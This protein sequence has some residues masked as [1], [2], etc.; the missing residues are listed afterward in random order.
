MA[1]SVHARTVIKQ[2]LRH[3]EGA[4]DTIVVD[5][6]THPSDPARLP[7]DA[8]K[9]M[10]ASTDYFHTRPI[11]GDELLRDMDQAGVDMAVCWQNPA[12][13]VYPGS[14]EA[15]F[16]SLHS[17]NRYIAELAE[18]HPT[19][20][21]PA[22]WTDPKALGQERAVDMA[23]ICIEEWG[24][25]I[26]KLNPAQNAYRID[27]PDVLGVVDRIVAFGATPAFHFGG[28]TEFTPADGLERVASRYAPH[29]VIAVHMGGGGSH[30]VHGDALYVAARELGLR[31]PNIFYVL[32][33]KRD[34]HIESDL[35]RYRLAGAPFANNLAVGS[36]APYGR[37]AWN[38]GGFHGI[39]AS[40]REPASHSDP[41][42]RANPDLFDDDAVRDIM[43]RNI[44][45][46]IIATDRR[47]LLLSEGRSGA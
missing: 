34:T 42:L 20:I 29:P 28:D 44:A 11:S 16:E 35:I 26:V 14:A 21:I 9:R 33:A 36:D 12:W 1:W 46:L 6:D 32:S 13:T 39:L 8:L 3:L 27:S 41:R 45:N 47:L 22:G 17:A 31:H 40:L 37:L 23:R 19:R 30:Y 24:F 7:A 43:G 4:R 38:F 2:R 18:K 25:P 10:A 5:G 15:N